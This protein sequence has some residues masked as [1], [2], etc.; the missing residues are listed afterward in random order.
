MGDYVASH[1]L[2]DVA[3]KHVEKLGVPWAQVAR[4]SF[5]QLV[6]VGEW[7]DGAWVTWD[8]DEAGREAA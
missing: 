4:L 1:A 3:R 7:R 5:G 6:V 2:A 8:A